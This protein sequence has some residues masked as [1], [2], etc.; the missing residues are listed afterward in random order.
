MFQTID[1]AESKFPI[2]IFTREEHA[3]EIDN[4]GWFAI[5]CC[6]YVYYDES[7]DPTCQIDVN[8]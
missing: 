6:S 7:I 1:S 8:Q 3:A 5:N 4:S 2:N